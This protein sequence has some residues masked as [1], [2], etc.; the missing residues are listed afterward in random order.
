MNTNPLP[1]G[2]I[3][4]KS[5]MTLITGNPILFH[6]TTIPLVLMRW[7]LAGWGIN[8]DSDAA[9][10]TLT[11]TSY[12]RTA[13]QYNNTNLTPPFP[14]WCNRHT[15]CTHWLSQINDCA[16]GYLFS[17]FFLFYTDVKV[18]L[19]AVT[20]IKAILIENTSLETKLLKLQ[21][22][23]TSERFGV[24]CLMTQNTH[25]GIKQ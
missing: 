13:E 4:K 14:S 15:S 22:Q 10:F 24:G 16:M 6:S 2:L 17:L 8:L 11:N 12:T 9:S 25:F 19:T 21:L 7:L 3:C 5:C 20:S 18:R 23:K 1:Q